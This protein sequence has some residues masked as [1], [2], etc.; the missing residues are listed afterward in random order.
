MGIAG[1]GEDAERDAL[2][3]GCFHGVVARQSAFEDY[4]EKHCG[5]DR[6][7]DD[8]GDPDNVAGPADNEEAEEEESQGDFETDGA[9]DVEGL[10]CADKLSLVSTCFGVLHCKEVCSTYCCIGIEIR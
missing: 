10:F 5:R 8:D 3:F 4:E 2:A 7:V 1:V 6:A 9:G